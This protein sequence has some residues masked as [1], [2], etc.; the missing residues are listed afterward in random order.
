MRG[1]PDGLQGVEPEACYP[2]ASVRLLAE[3]VRTGVRIRGR[4]RQASSRPERSAR[5][6]RRRRPCRQERTRG[7]EP[8]SPVAPGRWY[9]LASERA[10]GNTGSAGEGPGR[11]ERP[12]TRA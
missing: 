12:P 10:T 11:E 4:R 5:E 9:V 6:V 8:R 1:R 3:P 7:G 2:W